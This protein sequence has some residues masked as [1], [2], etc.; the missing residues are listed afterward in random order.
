M[1][2]ARFQLD[3]RAGFVPVRSKQKQAAF[4]KLAPVVPCI[5]IMLLEVKFSVMHTHVQVQFLLLS[6]SVSQENDKSEQWTE[7]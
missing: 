3:R 6:L 2:C 5:S 4:R 7:L 1:I